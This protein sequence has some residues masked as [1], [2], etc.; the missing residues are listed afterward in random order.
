MRHI[1]TL[2]IGIGGTGCKTLVEI[3]KNFTDEFGEGNIPEHIRFIGIDTDIFQE[4]KKIQKFFHITYGATTPQ[5]YYAIQ[6]ENNTGRCD[7]YT[8][9][10]NLLPGQ[11]CGTASNRSNARFLLEMDSYQVMNYI[12]KTLSELTN[13]ASYEFN[14]TEV[15]IRF[16]ISL[17]GGTGSGMLIPLA[18]MISQYK[19]VSIYG[20]SLL[21]GI[22][23]KYDLA[24]R[25]IDNA[26]MNC[27]ATTLELDYIQH[28]TVD[29]PFKIKICDIDFT[30][31]DQLFREFYMV[32]GTDGTGRFV[33][34]HEDL[35]KVLSLSMYSASF[36]CEHKGSIKHSI[37]QGYFN[38]ENK[39]GW[40]CSL[41]GCEITYRGDAAAKLQAYSDSRKIISK[42]IE[43]G[44]EDASAVTTMMLSGIYDIERPEY[45]D[46][47][48][49]KLELPRLVCTNPASNVEKIK[50]DI[51]TANEPINLSNKPSGIELHTYRNCSLT[52]LTK[53]LTTLDTKLPPILTTLQNVENHLQKNLEKILGDI[54]EMYLVLR[55]WKGRLLS[56]TPAKQDKLIFQLYNLI[57][58]AKTLQ[59]E[60]ALRRY[61]VEKIDQMSTEVRTYKNKCQALCARLQTLDLLLENDIDDQL[62]KLRNDNSSINH[63]IS[64]AYW[65]SKQALAG[66]INIPVGFTSTLL[67]YE[68]IEIGELHDKLLKVTDDS[69]AVQHYRD[70]II[71]DAIDALPEIYR[72]GIIRFLRTSANRML[73]LDRR[74]LM[75][76]SSTIKNGILTIYSKKQIPSLVKDIEQIFGQTINACLNHSSAKGHENRIILSYYEGAVLPYCIKAFTP[77]MI[78]IEYKEALERGKYNPHIDAK[79]FETLMTSNYTLAPTFS[80]IEPPV[81]STPQLES[82]PSTPIKPEPA[83]TSIH[84]TE[85]NKKYKVFIS[86]KSEDY[87]YAEQVYEFLVEHNLSVFLACRELKRIGEAEYALAIDSAL[88]ETE[89]MIVLLSSPDHA[90][91]KWVQYEW[92]TFE[93]D[94][95]SGYREGNLLVIKLPGVEQR[96]LPPGL[97]HKET[98]ILDSYK[99]SLLYYL[100]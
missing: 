97:R 28:A 60:I 77:E 7:W 75:P 34:Q 88:D 46:K 70:V 14:T 4:A 63:D 64:Y 6:K 94:K 65:K 38:Y 19:N 85:E 66:E 26:F 33:S 9:N 8:N 25:I 42:L 78:A 73:A 53:I 39:I 31:T 86:A 15:D 93:N 87:T 2:Y 32:E 99:D 56:F 20:Y 16:V 12:R 69:P 18:V 92:S 1:P 45:W 41:G 35:F 13:I 58:E 57:D 37:S 100:G 95:K 91:S 51:R 30:V 72:S 82:K 50:E 80:T 5:E 61:V 17:A 22:F 55:S 49:D 98:F 62:L 71:D 74:G 44:D 67:G 90:R 83:Q 52:D 23:R 11:K 43:S 76:T 29:C 24:D 36:D 89:H 48:K 54:D 81:P 84:M 10:T 40:L 59:Q 27:Y 47:L 21:H 96:K 3:Q 79:L 68:N